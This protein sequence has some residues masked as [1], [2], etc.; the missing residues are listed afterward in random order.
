MCRNIKTLYNFEPPTTEEEARAAALQYVR[1]VS[2]FAKPSK[3]NEVAFER[4]VEE[5]SAS[6][7]R[8]L[9]SLVTAAPPRNREVEAE[10]ARERARKR[11]PAAA[12]S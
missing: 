5:V 6:S 9:S 3:A 11:F 1:K 12:T 8:L 7:M 10:R 4:A 2:G